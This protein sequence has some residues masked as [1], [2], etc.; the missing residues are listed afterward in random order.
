L[1]PIRGSFEPS[2]R[3][4]WARRSFADCEYEGRVVGFFDDAL[5]DGTRS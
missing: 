2:S 1:Q 5:L 4:A 3:T